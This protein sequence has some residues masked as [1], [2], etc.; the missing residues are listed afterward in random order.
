MT[1]N[2]DNR[3]NL[4]DNPGTSGA[5]LGLLSFD[6]D[7]NF[8]GNVTTTPGPTSG[9]VSGTYSIN[10]NGTGTALVQ[11]GPNPPF[12]RL[13]NGS[14]YTWVLLLNDRCGQLASFQDHQNLGDNEFNPGTLIKRT[15]SAFAK[16]SLNGN[17]VAVESGLNKVVL[18]LIHF[19]GAG[20]ITVNASQ[21]GTGFGIGSGESITGTYSGPSGWNWTDSVLRS[22]G[23]LR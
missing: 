19:D 18:A 11:T 21:D 12:D 6:G 13:G 22:A 2:P 3:S 9:P 15:A 20:N 4:N 5:V 23:W 1:I 16:S 17:Y 7:G 14:P 8:S 10:S